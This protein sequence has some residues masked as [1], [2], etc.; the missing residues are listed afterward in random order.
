MTLFSIKNFT[1]STLLFIAIA[2][3]GWSIF[4]IQRSQ[5]STI[6][7]HPNEPDALMNDVK[8]T[9]LNKQGTPALKLDSP[10]MVHYPENDT[11]HMTKPHVVLYRQ[12][13]EP[14]YID[15]DTGQ[16]LYG[17]EQITF[18]KHVII[19]HLAD[20]S[21]PKTTMQTDSLIVYPNTQ[22]AHTPDPVLIIQPDITV[23]AVGMLA[24]LKEGTV[25]LL[26][27]ARGE[28]VPRS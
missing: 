15:S 7:Q 3:S 18:L 22:T 21:N 10:K 17:T 14:W 5:S 28:Y 20:A 16:G 27:Q 24:D 1:L 4:L 6:L 11:T 23:H 2:L 12:S 13:P 8:V 25:K 19:H 9:V 26:S